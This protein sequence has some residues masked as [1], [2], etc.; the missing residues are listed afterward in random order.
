MSVVNRVGPLDTR[1]RFAQ[2][3][4]MWCRVA[5][6]SDVGRVNGA[7]QALHREHSQSMSATAGS[8]PLTSLEERRQ[9]FASVFGSTGSKLPAAPLF[10]T[11]WLERH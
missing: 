2:D 4:E 5:A 7:D 11:I 1:L 3:M 9:V 8:A 10:S 6:V